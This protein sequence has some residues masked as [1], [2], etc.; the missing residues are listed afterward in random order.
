MDYILAYTKSPHSGREIAINVSGNKWY[1]S[2]HDSEEHVGSCSN[3]FSSLDYA[4]ER[5]MVYANYVIRGY[6][7]SEKLSEWVRNEGEE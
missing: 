5:Y 6:Y 1:L 3:H 2:F 7:N 4:I